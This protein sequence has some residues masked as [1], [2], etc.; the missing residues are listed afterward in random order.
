LHEF[1]YKFPLTGD[2]Y[3]RI[4]LKFLDCWYTQPGDRLFQIFLNQ[5]KALELDVIERVGRLTA[6]TE[7][8]LFSVCQGRVYIEGEEIELADDNMV[9]VNFVNVKNMPI[10]NAMAVVKHQRPDEELPGSLMPTKK[11]FGAP[12]FFECPQPKLGEQELLE[13]M[14]R[15]ATNNT[16]NMY[17]CVVNHYYVTE[18]SENVILPRMSKLSS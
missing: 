9:T 14:T 5:R 12:K 1:D 18:E 11:Y 4:I 10:L 3:Y 2:G 17:N 15:N 6:L 13:T 16:I 8:V 7:N